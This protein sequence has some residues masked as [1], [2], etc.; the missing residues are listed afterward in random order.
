MRGGVR[1]GAGRKPVEIDL[2]ELQ[3]LCSLQCTHEEIASWFNCSVRTIEKY[4]KKP[5]V[6]EVMAR[7]KA[8]GAFRC[9]GRR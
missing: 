6:A 3:K 2:I 5:E 7:G 9:A 1:H 8:M 4:S